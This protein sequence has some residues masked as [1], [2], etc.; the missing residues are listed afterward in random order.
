MAPD[1]ISSSRRDSGRRYSPAASTLPFAAR[2]KDSESVLLLDK[3]GVIG[4][5]APAS[6]GDYLVKP[7]TR[8]QF[9]DCCN[10]FWWVSPY[11]AKG[12]WRGE[13]VYAK[14]MLDENLREQLHKMVNW[15]IGIRTEFQVN[16][17]K[18][19]KYFERYL[20]PEKW[21]LLLQTY[22]DA[23]YENNWRALFAMGDLFR[24]VGVPVA[25]HFGY[26]YPRGEDERVTAHLR[27]VRSLPKDA[28]EMY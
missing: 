14:A 26:A 7:P 9:D 24:A 5:L 2:P 10:E 3:D 28:E 17:G 13:I 21:E 1:R 8:K 19:G 22:A 20:E 6:D 23:G 4:P 12:L 25:E 16:P 11:A 15:H 27:H 18:Y